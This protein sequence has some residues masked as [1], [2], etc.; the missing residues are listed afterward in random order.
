MKLLRLLRECLRCIPILAFCNLPMIWNLWTE[1]TIGY[2]IALTAVLSLWYLGSM[3]RIYRKHAGSRRLAAISHG[4]RE[5]RYYMLCTLAEPIIYFAI[6]PLF[7]PFPRSWETLLWFVENVLFFAVFSLIMVIGG[8]IRLGIA[9]RQ[10]KWYWYLILYLVWWMPVINLI[11]FLHIYRTARRELYFE[12]A[13]LE[14]DAVRRE[15]EICKTR[16]PILLVHGIFFRDWQYF[17]YWGRI[18]AALRKNGAEVYYGNQQSSQSVA[19]SAAELNE[20]IR[21]VL[22]ETGAEKLNIIA[23]SKGGLDARYAMAMLGAAPYVASLTT[24]NTPHHGCA[25]VDRILHTMPTAITQWIAARYEKVFRGL[26]DTTP[27]FLSG[28]RDLTVERC[29]QFNAAHPIDPSVPHHCV[30]SE[31]CSLW[32]APFPLWLGYLCNKRERLTM[33]NDGL[34]PVE[35]ARI[36]GAAFTMIPKT[37]HRGISHGDMIDLNRENIEGFDVRE[38]Y[39]GVVKGLKEQGL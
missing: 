5:L 35:S 39:V 17:N 21:E 14:L 15:N 1:G 31:M 3:F 8:L 27:D 38:F 9:A 23:H 2:K 24:I 22:A 29:E 30:M 28:V 4:L 7:V 36:D 26:G 6:L 19:K 18:P 25:W 10:V 12:A 11:P 13:K 20:R 37:K 16:Y 33:R 32:S 34:V